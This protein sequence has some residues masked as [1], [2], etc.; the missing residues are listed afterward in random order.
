[1]GTTGETVRS[2]PLIAVSTP[3]VFLYVRCGS[4]SRGKCGS[5]LF[6]GALVTKHDMI[7]ISILKVLHLYTYIHRTCGLCWQFMYLVN[8]ILYFTVT[9]IESMCHRHLILK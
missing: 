1:M 8:I 3:G 6:N 5:L 9:Y 4:Y 2:L 7:N